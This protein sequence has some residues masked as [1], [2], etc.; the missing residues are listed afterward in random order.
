MGVEAVAGHLVS[1][2]LWSKPDMLR[3][4]GLFTRDASGE[5]SA[6]LHPT[7]A[8]ALVPIERRG[9]ILELASLALERGD[10][11]VGRWREV[12]DLSRSAEWRQLLDEQQVSHDV[13][14]RSEV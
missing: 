6:E 1:A 4:R 7:E 3:H 12:L 11:T 14:H 2:G 5:D 8:E 10:I 9:E 13:E